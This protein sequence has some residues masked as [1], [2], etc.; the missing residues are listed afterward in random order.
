ME[1]NLQDLLS[2]SFR[3]VLCATGGPQDPVMAVS[4]QDMMSALAKDQSP[5]PLEVPCECELCVVTGEFK[6]KALQR[7]FP[8]KT[9]NTKSEAKRVI[10]HFVNV[11]QT[12]RYLLH[13]IIEVHGETLTNRWR[14]K[15]M[16]QR[17]KAITEFAPSMCAQD[18]PHVRTQ[19]DMWD[20]EVTCSSQSKAME[21]MQLLVPYLNIERLS[22]DKYHLLSLLY[23]RLQHS[24]AEFAVSDARE[25]V[26]SWITGDLKQPFSPGSVSMTV[27]NFGHWN[28][29][30]DLVQI[31]RKNAFGATK[32]ASFLQ[33]QR[34]LYRFL[35][36]ISV[37]ILS[38][39]LP[40][41][42][43]ESDLAGDG[44]LLADV[45]R[46]VHKQARSMAESDGLHGLFELRNC[47]QRSAF[48]QPHG[49]WKSFLA[50]HEARPFQGPYNICFD[51]LIRLTEDRIAELQDELWLLQT[52][53]KNLLR[54]LHH[55]E[56]RNKARLKGCDIPKEFDKW[57]DIA[58][59][60]LWTPLTFY[61][62]WKELRDELFYL[63]DSRQ[64]HRVDLR[65]GGHLPAAYGNALAS[66]YKQV[67]GLQTSYRRVLMHSLY[68]LPKARNL[69][70]AKGVKY[71]AKSQS[72][73]AH[74]NLKMSSIGE[75][76]SDKLLCMLLQLCLPKYDCF[77]IDLTSILHFLDQSTGSGGIFS[78]A[79]LHS[80]DY[81][82]LS[83]LAILEEIAIAC[84]LH[85]PGYRMLTLDDVHDNPRPYWERNR[86][87]RDKWGD[88]PP[89]IALTPVGKTLYPLSR[90]RTPADLRSEE[91]IQ[92]S[93]RAFAA[94][95][96]IWTAVE[97]F[98]TT[99]SNGM[100]YDGMFRQYHF[101][102]VKFY[103]DPD[104]I[105]RIEHM[106]DTSRKN[107]EVERELLAIR[108]LSVHE[109]PKADLTVT[110]KQKIK[111]KGDLITV[112]TQSLDKDR[113]STQQEEYTPPGLYALDQKHSRLL[114]QLFGT[115]DNNAVRTPEDW[116]AF[117]TFMADVGFGMER[118]GGSMVRFEGTIALE[119][120]GEKVEKHRSIMI[121][122]PHPG[123]EMAPEMLSD[124]G[125]R[126]AR[127]FGW[128]RQHFAEV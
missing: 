72:V 81:S 66:F 105:G 124:I 30:V 39:K 8:Y 34:Y 122:R 111:T 51:D 73:S 95:N 46:K 94:L 35:I 60:G 26:P 44:Q 31:H 96:S 99:A 33:A 110:Q 38:D 27:E 123:N 126:L 90:L 61:A 117:E 97:Q 18:H 40:K 19:L 48:S 53:P 109:S 85:R 91:N 112:A 86:F 3:Q 114:D 65:P 63:Q 17:T 9:Q 10:E 104:Q 20:A 36:G 55:L 7:G 67:R 2:Q 6:P 79:D 32:A 84:E 77:N 58:N 108:S 42:R 68:A 64:K 87:K 56:S 52:D 37:H 25:F 125:R 107:L 62:E 106:H 82:V 74:L 76:I 121:H 100:G 127:R 103:K 119:E 113:Q 75:T 13:Q 1:G 102:G 24:P 23:H 128:T 70:E 93:E 29:N 118:C 4:F 80:S 41:Y 47:V 12:L 54:A 45:Y 21:L 49:A 88:N 101:E 16:K 89:D 69:F 22:K 15:N 59:F 92:Q 50:R 115:L 83:D 78:K 5:I 71:D 57:G 43:F 98:I 28:R 14:R 11:A 116:K 120:A